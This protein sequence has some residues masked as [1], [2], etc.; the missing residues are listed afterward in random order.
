MQSIWKPALCALLALLLCS[1]SLLTPPSAA[2]QAAQTQC[3]ALM[4]G[5]SQGDWSAAEAMLP[6]GG[7]Y[8]VAPGEEASLLNAMAQRMSYKIKSV[9]EQEDGSV[10]LTLRIQNVD[11]KKLLESLP[12]GLSSTEEARAA[13]LE[14]M[15]DAKRKSF[16]A[17]LTLLPDGEGE[18]WELLCDVSFANA[19]TGGLYDIA[20]ELWGEASAQ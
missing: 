9:Q 19:L 12:E 13:M 18:G 8:G 15:S 11:L 4:D 5:L 20:Q 17:Q 1:C 14:R 6:L 3:E 7:L 10:V 2:E 16:D